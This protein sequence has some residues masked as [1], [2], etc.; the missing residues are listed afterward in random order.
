MKFRFH[1]GGYN[2]SM[3]TTRTV[4]NIEQIRTLVKNK[5]K[6]EY[7]HKLV[8]IEFVYSG[9]DTRNGWD[10]YLVVAVFDPSG[11]IVVGMSDG[12]FE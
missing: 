7:F 5:F 10:T 3:K 9:M 11:E 6:H 2:E 8:G 4:E 12:K 1:L